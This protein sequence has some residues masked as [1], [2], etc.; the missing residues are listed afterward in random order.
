VTVVSAFQVRR[1]NGRRRRDLLRATTDPGS[2]TTFDE[3]LG[4]RD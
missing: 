1:G 4:D 3:S 2:L